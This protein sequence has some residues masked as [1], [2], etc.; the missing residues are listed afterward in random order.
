MTEGSTGVALL[1]DPVCLPLSHAAGAGRA[2]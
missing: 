1:C 2:A